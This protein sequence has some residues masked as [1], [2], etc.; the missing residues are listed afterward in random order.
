MTKQMKAIVKDTGEII[1]VEQ[2]F[3]SQTYM[4]E[5]GFPYNE[6]ELNFLSNDEVAIEGFMVRSKDGAMSVFENQ[7]HRFNGHW[8]GDYVFAEND[9]PDLFPGLTWDDEPQKVTIIIR[10]K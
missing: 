5:D 3:S 6:S 10:T 1:N 7:P 2:H 9:S 8:T 4:G